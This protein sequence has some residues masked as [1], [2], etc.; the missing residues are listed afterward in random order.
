MIETHFHDDIN[1][2]VIC[3][4]NNVEYLM[5]EEIYKNSDKVITLLFHLI[6]VMQSKKCWT[7][8]RF[9][10]NLNC[11]SIVLSEAKS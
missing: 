2:C 10:R 11:T 4:S 9:I 1:D 7:K 8:F 5:K 6:I 3:I